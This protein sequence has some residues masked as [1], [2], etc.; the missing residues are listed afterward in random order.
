MFEKH[1][2]SLLWRLQFIHL[3]I[4]QRRLFSEQKCRNWREYFFNKFCIE[5]CLE[6]NSKW[7][8]FIFFWVQKKQSLSKNHHWKLQ[9]KFDFWQMRSLSARIL[10]RRKFKLHRKSF[11]CYC[12]LQSLQNCFGMHRMLRQIFSSQ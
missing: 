3:H 2:N 5:K 12:K 1:W 10:F 7:C 11:A 4:M 8:L 9:G 6:P